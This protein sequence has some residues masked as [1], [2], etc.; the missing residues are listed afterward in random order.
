MLEEKK[1]NFSPIFQETLSYKIKKYINMHRNENCWWVPLQY[2]EMN[3][4]GKK[5][6]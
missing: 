5:R 3:V 6:K 4:S 1:S 2:K